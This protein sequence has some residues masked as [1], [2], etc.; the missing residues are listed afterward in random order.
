MLFWSLRFVRDQHIY[1]VR[2]RDL[3]ISEIPSHPTNK[4]NQ[5]KKTIKKEWSI[6]YNSSILLMSGVLLNFL[7]GMQV[8]DASWYMPNEKRDTLEEY[9][10]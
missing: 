2:C 9:K 3:Q 7:Q 5:T 6:G 1:P 10:V 4:L 8:V